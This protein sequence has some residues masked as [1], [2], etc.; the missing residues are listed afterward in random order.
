MSFGISLKREREL[1]GISLDEI[2]K[3]TKISVR[4]LEAI[5]KDRFD[6]L[7]EGVFRKSFIKSYAKYLG[8]NEEQILQEYALQVELRAAPQASPERPSASLSV[9][10]VAPRQA[11]LVTL[12]ILLLLAAAGLGL[13][14]FSQAKDEAEPAPSGGQASA[15]PQT[16]G[17]QPSG[18]KTVPSD[19]AE[20]Q[21][22]AGSNA[23]PA[24]SQIGA[25][26]PPSGSP[27]KPSA[28]KV[29]G[30]LAK[31]PEAAPDGRSAA[32]PLELTV[33]A[34]N[35]VWISVNAGESLLF[36]G[37]MTPQE[38]KKFPLE[39]PLK[40]ILGNAGGVKI[41]VNGQA[42]SSLGKSGERKTLEIS[43]ENYQQY[44]A[45]KTP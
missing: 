4:L 13:W 30:E 10:P 40:L 32:T 5:E 41:L 44:L 29:L 7:P 31:K 39:A 26:V 27:G 37:L 3:A 34:E 43:A 17:S 22:P 24:A 38:S 36:A 9:S 14:Y 8:M 42:F 6:I 21:P 20:S 11:L 28:L 25:T 12:G 2:S 23:L 1:R 16:P 33:E 45:A 19:A 15:V 35:P 18:E